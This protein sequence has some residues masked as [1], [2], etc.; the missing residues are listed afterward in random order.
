MYFLQLPTEIRLKIYS[1]ILGD[2]LVYL[3]AGRQDISARA[4]E[5]EMLPASVVNAYP[6]QRGAQI[7]RTCKSILYEARPILYRDTIFRASFQAFAGRLPTCIA[8]DNP[9]QPHIKHIDW[10][11]NCDLLKKF[12]AKDVHILAQD[13]QTL[14]TVRISCQAENWRDSFCGA[15]TDREVFVRGR[16][17]VIDFAQLLRERMLESNRV[18]RLAEDTRFLSRGRVVLRLFTG[19]TTISPD[20]SE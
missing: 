15:W 1:E 10:Q 14:E 5:P 11:L 4:A 13:V 9:S 20:V 7:L 3:N 17:Q 6:Q 16:Q 8:F 19:R 18:V 12:D 2:G